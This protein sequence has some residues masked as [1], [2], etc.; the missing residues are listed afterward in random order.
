MMYVLHMPSEKKVVA[1]LSMV[2]TL[3][4]FG[5]DAISNGSAI[6]WRRVRRKLVKT[7]NSVYI[8]ESM[9]FLFPWG[10]ISIQFQRSQWIM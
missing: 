9:L 8:F 10:T 6:C 5:I 3:V 4:S 1:Y 2:S 7:Q